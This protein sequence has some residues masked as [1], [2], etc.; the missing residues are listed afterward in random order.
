MANS[1]D[2]DQTPH[3][4]ASDLVLHT[5]LKPVAILNKGSNW[6]FTLNF[7]FIKIKNINFSTY[8]RKSN[9]FG[10]KWKQ[11]L[12]GRKLGP[13]PYC[14]FISESFLSPS[15]P[16]SS[17]VDARDGNSS[18]KYGD[19]CPTTGFG[20]SPIVTLLQDLTPVRGRQK[21]LEAQCKNMYLL[22]WAHNQH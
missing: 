11:L 20:G 2:P 5:L 9:F 7:S 15:F 13:G 19:L 21:E 6:Q 3:S 10:Q 22:I 4:L 12:W 1:T 18:W 16:L 17:P 8:Q 14:S